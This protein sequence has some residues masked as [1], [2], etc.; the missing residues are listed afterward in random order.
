MVLEDALH[1]GS[2]PMDDERRWYTV[3]EAAERLR[4]SH[5]T[6][7]RLIARGELPAI[8]VSARIIR[9][10]KPAL[11]RYETGEPIVRR[12]V[13]WTHVDHIEPIGADEGIPKLQRSR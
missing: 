10:P 6:V 5:D 8:R 4:V 9:I 13:A 3:K 1:A 7:S 12:E 2:R 11:H